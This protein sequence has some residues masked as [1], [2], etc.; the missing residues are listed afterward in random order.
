MAP[1]CVLFFFGSHAPRTA[2]SKA[3]RRRLA[4][5][6]PGRAADS[7]GSKDRGA[8]KIQWVCDLAGRFPGEPVIVELRRQRPGRGPRYSGL[9]W[10]KRRTGSLRDMGYFFP[11]GLCQLLERGASFSHRPA[12][13]S[14]HARDPR[15]PNDSWIASAY[16]A[17]P[18]RL[19]RL[20][21]FPLRRPASEKSSAIPRTLPRPPSIFTNTR[22]S[23]KLPPP[24]AGSGGADRLLNKVTCRIWAEAGHK[25]ANASAADNSEHS[26]ARRGR[27]F[28][29]STL[30]HGRAHRFARGISWVYRD[31]W[32][33][34]CS[35][36]I[37]AFLFFLG[38]L[39]G[40]GPGA[41]QAHGRAAA[42][43]GREQNVVS[44]LGG[45]GGRGIVVMVLD[46]L[47]RAGGGGVG[48]VILVPQMHGAV[49]GAWDQKIRSIPRIIAGL[50]KNA[51][52]GNKLHLAGSNSRRQGNRPPPGLLEALV[53]LTS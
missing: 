36:S 22:R 34:I 16:C 14:D 35:C 32:L 47:K 50:D 30:K 39:A 52:L 51:I 40:K 26:R 33:R 18:R 24:P 3:C 6:F 1:F 19:A 9:R 12:Q 41:G 48:C 37:P 28:N 31:A 10:K 43:S 7:K 2:Q 15:D 13:R 38:Y 25:T 17:Y 29:L 8:L 45:D 49:R 4:R 42:I 23:S 27:T 11:A 46:G 20:G 53:P 44:H 5:L 21:L